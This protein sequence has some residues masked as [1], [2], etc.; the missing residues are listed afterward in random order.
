[1]TAWLAAALAALAA[2]AVEAVRRW[3]GARAREKALA[4]ELAAA[5]GQA[6]ARQDRAIAVQTDLEEEILVEAQA[7]IDAG[8]PG[9]ERRM[10][11]G[12]AA[13][14]TDGDR[15]VA[16]REAARPGADPAIAA[17]VRGRR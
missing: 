8:D 12:W 7:R 14:G 1:M 9:A 15:D 5:K 17:P 6:A 16:P 3:R 2:I 10:R 11:A 13:G 4:A